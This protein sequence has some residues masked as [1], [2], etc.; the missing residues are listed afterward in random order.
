MDATTTFNLN[1]F[2]CFFDS[3]VNCN[4]KLYT[5]VQ[6]CVF[7]CRNICLSL[8]ELNIL[9]VTESSPLCVI[10][11]T[12]ISIF[13]CIFRTLIQTKIELS[14]EIWIRYFYSVFFL[15]ALTL[16]A[17]FLFKQFQWNRCSDR[18][19]YI[20]VMWVFANTTLWWYYALGIDKVKP[21]FHE[22]HPKKSIDT[23][24]VWSSS[25]VVVIAVV[26]N[27]ASARAAWQTNYTRVFM[28][29][30]KSRK[31]SDFVH[32]GQYSE[33]AYLSWPDSIFISQIFFFCCMFV[34]S[35]YLIFSLLLPVIYWQRLTLCELFVMLFLLLPVLWKVYYKYQVFF[36]S[37]DNTL[38]SHDT[39][40]NVNNVLWLLHG[41]GTIAKWWNEPATYTQLYEF[42]K[43]SNCRR[44]SC[45]LY[46]PVFSTS[47]KIASCC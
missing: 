15:L 32:W 46:S 36:L 5:N 35:F 4:C 17:L 12:L 10:L 13:T 37:I 21:K 38:N 39:M 25:F 40:I 14:T 44:P 23:S 30:G 18:T 19:E 34:W 33:A 27:S 43:Q 20:Q 1:H 42:Q 11:L 22:T 26:T 2:V 7:R 9:S 3:S 6:V 31:P 24:T 45:C 29:S 16:F 41:N 47:F 8:S 28:D